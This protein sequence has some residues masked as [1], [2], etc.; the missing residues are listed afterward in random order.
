MT[1]D[2]LL[3]R[4]KASLRL[5]PVEPDSAPLFCFVLLTV[6]C[7]LASFAFACATPFAAFAVV[8]AAMLPLIPAVAAVTG[9]W[10]VSQG[11]GFGALHYPVEANTILWGLAIGLAALVATAASAVVLRIWPQNV[12][13]LGLALALASALA[14]AYCSYELI[15]FAATPF[16]GGA[17][18]F[19]IPLI[20]RLGLLS[21]AWLFAL[22]AICEIARLLSS[23]WRGHA[24]R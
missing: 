15:I 24:A 13:P 23:E 10:L 19:S 1:L 3:G 2:K 6:S 8:A 22:V 14:G 12:T 18:N 21:T 7:A 17:E 9:A 4:T 11:I 16:L 20:I 5:T